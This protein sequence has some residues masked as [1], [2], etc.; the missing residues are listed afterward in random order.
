MELTVKLALYLLCAV[1]GYLFG[2]HNLA[3]TIS[4]Q[5][6][7]DIRAVGSG[8][9]GTSNA[10]IT[11][12]WKIGVLVGAHDIFK[13]LIPA[14]LAAFLLP[15]LPL[16]AAVTGVASVLGHIFPAPLKFKGGKGFAPYVGMTFA[17]NWKFGLAVIVIVVL[18]IVIT[19]YLSV[20]TFT[21]VISFPIYI[22]LF[23]CQYPLAA[24]VTVASVV[25]VWRHRENITRIANGTEIGFRGARKTKDSHH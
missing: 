14:L 20:A 15:S 8:N 13:A 17:V 16:A 18:A 1:S 19:D 25:I 21:T 22:A 10:V 11:M 9:P 3:H 2:C 6:G 24:V 7:F 23:L 5:R 12:G 4:K